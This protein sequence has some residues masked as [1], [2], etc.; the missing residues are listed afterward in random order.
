L[1]SNA[2]TLTFYRSLMALPVFVVI[3]L[4]R[5][6]PIR[7]PGKVL[8]QV[9]LVALFGT[10]LT[11][12][13]LY[14][15]YPYIGVGVST[16]LHFLYPI[17]A[18]LICRLLFRERLGGQKVAALI[19]AT[20][21]VVCFLEQGAMSAS[22]GIVLALVSAV[23][24]A[25][26]MVAMEKLKLS[27]HNPLVISFYIAIV[28]PLEMLAYNAFVDKIVFALPPLA[29]FYT[30]VISMCTSLAAVCLLQLGIRYL[31]AT[32]A[33]ILSLFEP[34]SSTVSGVLIL[35]EQMDFRTLLGSLLI[36]MGI[37]ILVLRKEPS[38]PAEADAV[39][40]E[41]K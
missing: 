39:G 30:F 26:Y 2:E 23:T 24:Y 15:A 1:G 8:C 41:Q 7:L 33:A 36:L 37:V 6:I 35:H 34:L 3:L 18:A 11:T 32:T 10:G 19:V 12:L 40:A 38:H 5:R 27:D 28:V 31:S 29:L 25:S 4:A 16:S 20:A 14:S 22:V 9:I 17:V 13:L 21:G